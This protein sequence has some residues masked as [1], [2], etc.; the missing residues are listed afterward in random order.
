[1]ALESIL[2]KRGSLI[3]VGER[4]I[5]RVG[6]KKERY[7]IYLPLERNY[8]WRKLWELGKIRVYIEV[9]DLAES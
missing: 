8:I 4:R 9:V 1:M 6:S 5:A 2:I 7:L 3:D